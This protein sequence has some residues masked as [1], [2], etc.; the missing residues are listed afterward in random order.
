[1]STEILESLS[2]QANPGTVAAGRGEP[3]KRKV[4]RVA[5]CYCCG[6]VLLLPLMV[7]SLPSSFLFRL[8][9][10]GHVTQHQSWNSFPQKIKGGPGVSPRAVWSKAD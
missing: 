3:I 4:N 1:M 8:F 9:E 2:V 6:F 5:L 7:L 10:L